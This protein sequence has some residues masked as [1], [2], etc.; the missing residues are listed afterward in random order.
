MGNPTFF[1]DDVAVYHK[2]NKYIDDYY[3][4]LH[5]SGQI[6]GMN[7]QD[8]TNSC[9][10]FVTFEDKTAKCLIIKQHDTLTSDFL[11]NHIKPFFPNYKVVYKEVKLIDIVQ[12][13]VDGVVENYEHRTVCFV[14]NGQLC[15]RTNVEFSLDEFVFNTNM[16]TDKISP[17]ILRN[18]LKKW[19]SDDRSI[20]EFINQP[21]MLDNY[22]SFVKF[23]QVEMATTLTY[24]LNRSNY[25]GFK[26]FMKQL[27]IE[28]LHASIVDLKDDSSVKNRFDILQTSAATKKTT[29]NY[30]GL[31]YTPYAKPHDP[32]VQLFGHKLKISRGNFYIIEA[33][34]KMVNKYD[35]YITDV[36][37]LK[38]L[39]C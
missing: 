26:S 24:K 18:K 29:L 15:I 13:F 22:Q 31:S 14:K 11:K 10:A 20:R 7:F 12:P 25:S 5:Q 1:K 9:I 32:Y 39:Y 36:E 2:N 35:D 23:A 17:N 6:D 34:L 37:R 33:M 19:G 3:E 4:N 30:C 16:I 21:N 8:N 28:T 38:L 27:D